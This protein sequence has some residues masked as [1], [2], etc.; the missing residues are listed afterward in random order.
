MSGNSIV[1]FVFSVDDVK[2][3]PQRWVLVTCPYY[4]CHLHSGIF[5][6]PSVEVMRKKSGKSSTVFKSLP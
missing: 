4:L 3:N 6:M 5:S 2:Q 1:D